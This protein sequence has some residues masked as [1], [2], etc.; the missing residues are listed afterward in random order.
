MINP[1]SPNAFIVNN[2]TISDKLEISKSFNKYRSSIGLKTNQNVHVTNMKFTDYLPNP[3]GHGMCLEP[4]T[5]LY[6]MMK[7]ILNN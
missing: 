2:T 1:V 4:E 7:Y 3:T 5:P 6:D